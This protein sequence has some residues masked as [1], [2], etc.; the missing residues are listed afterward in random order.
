MLIEEYPVHQLPISHFQLS[1]PI[2]ESM[3]NAQTFFFLFLTGKKQK[4]LNDNNNTSVIYSTN[5]SGAEHFSRSNLAWLMTCIK[6]ESKS[7]TKLAE[8]LYAK[9]PF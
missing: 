2:T 9:E 3:R 5:A 8:T 1:T 6:N 7:L 4:K